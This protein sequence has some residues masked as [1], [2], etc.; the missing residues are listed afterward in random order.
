M[1]SHNLQSENHTKKRI[2]II[3]AL[4]YLPLIYGLK[5]D[6]VEHDF[7]L[8]HSSAAKSA[9]QLREG[10]L[11]LALIQS[12]DYAQKKETWKIIPEICIACNISVKNIQL[13]FKRDLKQIKK[14]AVD[15]NANTAKI[16]LKILMKEKFM[17]SPEY[18]EMNPDVIQMLSKADAALI[19][20]NEALDIYQKNRNRIDLNEEWVDMTGLP[21]V[22]S[23][24][25][26]REFTISK[27]ETLQIRKSYELGIRNLEEISKK[28][29]HNHSESWGFYHD[30][31][32][33]NINYHFSE[34]EKEGLME[35][36]NY[37]FFFSF[38][39][40]IPDLH[41]YSP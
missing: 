29:A 24:W 30:F 19:V 23:F 12:I 1:W 9:E 10:E 7:E 36:Y 41:F 6:M 22:Y 25:A 28:F 18:I 39:D 40:F 4:E 13:F 33:K 16:L 5:N 37:A 2:G 11:E 34:Q 21:F 17:M 26:G 27:N 8:I 38:V 35:F 3:D 20:G 15:K 32:T 14:I 31:L